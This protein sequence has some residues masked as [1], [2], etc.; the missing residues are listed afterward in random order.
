MKRFIEFWRRNWA[1]LS[2]KLRHPKWRHGR[3]STLLLGGFLAV[4]VLLNIGI[5]ALETEYGWR[6]DYS[7]NGY[8]TTGEE[9]RKVVDRLTR[10][11]DL[12]LL[13]QGGDIDSQ[14][15]EVLNRYGVLSEMIHVKPTDIA[16]NPGILTR[17]QGTLEI[18]VESGVVIVSCEATDRYRLLNYNDFVTQGYNTESGTFEMAGLAYEKKLTEALA[19]VAEG[20]VPVIGLLQGHGELTLTELANLT[21]FFESNIYECRAVNLLSGDS[22][23]DVG[24]LLIASPTKDLGTEELQAINTFAQEGGSLFITRDFTDSMNLPNYFSL[25]R[26]YGVVPLS[27]VVVAGE[28]EQDTYYGER[29]YL[30][31]EMCELDMTLPLILGEMDELLLPAASAFEVPPEADANLSVA[32]VLKSG[33]NAYLRTPTTQDPSIDRQ[34]DDRTG[35]LSL[36]L[37]AHRMHAT[38]N[39]SRLFAI[40]NSTLFTDEFMYQRTYNEAFLLQIMGE[41]LPQKTVSLDIMA[42][43]AFHPALR[44]S[45]QVTGLALIIAVPLMTLTA[46]LCVLLPRRNR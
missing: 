33:K 4:C 20:T 25:L 10:E 1:R 45:S 29:I 23:E 34:P 7:F 12:Y 15:L 2:Q 16:K 6:K 14:L 13:Y 19:Y 35:E 8:A 3:F 17:F 31:P 22:L 43:S 42:S 39:I 5:S 40:G 26:N 38:G 36:A 41:L 28:N 44:P 46:A 18:A 11:V 24:M 21:D 32:T 37:Y 30:L 27:G 9:T